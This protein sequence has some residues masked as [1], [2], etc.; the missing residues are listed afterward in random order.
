MR[1]DPIN[2]TYYD[3]AELMNGTDLI[4]A[5]PNNMDNIQWKSIHGDF[6][7]KIDALMDNFLKE[8]T[9]KIKDINIIDLNYI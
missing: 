1:Y 4:M 8:C 3:Q 7:F 2:N 5:D 9:H 6:I